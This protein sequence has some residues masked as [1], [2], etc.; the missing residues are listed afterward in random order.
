[1]LDFINNDVAFQDIPLGVY[2]ALSL[3][4]YGDDNSGSLPDGWSL[5]SSFKAADGYVGNCYVKNIFTTKTKFII[6]HR[7]TVLSS[8]K[9]IIADIEVALGFIPDQLISVNNFI[10]QVSKKVRD[11]YESKPDLLEYISITSTG[12]SL[13]AVLSDLCLIN[14]LSFSITFE[15]PGS[16]QLIWRQINSFPISSKDKTYLYNRVKAS[17][18]TYQA[19]VNIINTWAEQI[20][21]VYYLTDL[22]YDYFDQNNDVDPKINTNYILNLCYLRYSLEQHRMNNINNYINASGTLEK[23]NYP[24]GPVNGYLAYLDN[25]RKSYWDG[26]SKIIWSEY[27]FVR[28][29]FQ[30]NKEKYFIYFYEQLS[31][32]RQA[33]GC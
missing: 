19:D 25:N 15:N 8:A 33:V 30:N 14:P 9:D 28:D 31:L 32:T 16:A 13:G 10:L 26:Y 24:V 20:G 27:Q 6:A 11:L 29:Q 21:D 4:V 1:M 17:A 2:S 7:G 18:R 5:F 3:H 23:K 12:H 22:G